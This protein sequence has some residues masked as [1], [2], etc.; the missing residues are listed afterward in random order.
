METTRSSTALRAQL[1]VRPAELADRPGLEAIEARI[2]DG[3]DYLPHVIDDW[4]N[5][6]YN[7]FY[8][9]AL[10]DQIVGTVK[11]TR[12]AEGEWWMEGL[13]VDPD[14]HQQGI[15]RILHHFVINQVRQYR[16][17]VVRFTTSSLNVAVHRL[18][19][20][21]GFEHKASYLPYSAPPLNEPV[22]TLVP[23][24]PAD[25]P[26]V[27]AW[28]EGSPHFARAQRSYESD[29]SL[30][31][32]TDA[33]LATRLETGLVYGWGEQQLQGVVIVNPA[34]D[35]SWPDSELLKIAYLDPGADVAA[36]LRDVRRLAAF[37][38][39]GGVRLKALKQPERIQ[40]LANAGFERE[41][42]GEVWLYARDLSLT[43]FAQ[44]LTE[45]L[46]PL[47]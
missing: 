29:W 32:L 37:L 25:A 41:W 31:Y 36:C 6:P 13:R 22:Q 15:S 39:R 20:Q 9:A 8:V 30:Y 26:R 24:T 19:L 34:R 17:G 47:S 3:D 1:V 27:R 7:G 4:F 12:F 28:L 23:L 45:E 2:W 40:A 10:H 43:R 5:D 46:P 21:T 42:D 14:Y 35:A 16:Y 18:A 33:R 44:V 38:E 11:L